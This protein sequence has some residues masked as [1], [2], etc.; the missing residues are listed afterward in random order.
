MNAAVDETSDQLEQQ[1]PEGPGARLR[2]ARLANGL[3]LDRVAAQ[4]HI[5]PHQVEALEQDNYDAFAAR[6]FVR[7][8]VRNYAR[9][10]NLSADAML[11]MFDAVYPDPERSRELRRVGTHRPQVG[12]G[13]GVVRMVSW[14]LL[15]GILALFLVWWAGYLELNGGSGDTDT[16][17]P[18]TTEGSA[19]QQLP[20][21]PLDESTGQLPLPPAPTQADEVE[22]D[23][24]SAEQAESDSAVQM[25]GSAVAP[26]DETSPSAAVADQPA[27][28]APDS[29][30]PAVPAQAQP[31]VVLS[32]T[33]PCWVQI[34]DSSNDFKLIGEFKA[35]TRRVLEGTPPYRIL[36]GNASVAELTVNG[37]VVDL[38]PHTRGQVARFSLDPGAQ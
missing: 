36:L 38:A 1:N 18:I 13:H 34:R 9:L 22:Q 32:L 6:V 24:V 35:G 15:L 21:L 2:A 14:A 7:G 29:E 4:L 3:E 17:A 11:A 10:V 16:S 26:A 8:Y 23:A 19:P 33:G 20:G 25:T 37:Q 30:P 5:Q 12:S 28:L 31:E 27:A